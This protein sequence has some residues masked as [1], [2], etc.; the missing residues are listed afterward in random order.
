MNEYTNHPET[1]A[2]MSID[3]T[4]RAVYDHAYVARYEAYPE[5]WLSMVRADLINQH[6]PELRWTAKG[7]VMD[8]GFGTGA[9]L[10]ELH[11]RQWWLKLHGYDV[12]PYPAPEC[13]TVT[14]DWIDREW[15]LITFFD[16]LE[17]FADLSWLA[18]LKAKRAIVSVPWYHPQQGPDWFASWKHRRPGEHLWH[19]TPET[20]TN[21]MAKA[22]L[23]PVY[24]G[25]PEDVVRVGDGK[26]PNILTICFSR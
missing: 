18:D 5:S 20:L 16:S 3:R 6:F 22:G 19:F 14:P 2:L 10:R 15:D 26:L 9:F 7:T 21:T 12:S 4:V 23:W 13:V 25:S 11:A 24:V 1:G 17:H 8:V